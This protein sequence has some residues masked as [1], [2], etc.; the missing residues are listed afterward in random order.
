MPYQMKFASWPITEG[1]LLTVSFSGRIDEPQYG[2]MPQELA[3]ALSGTSPSHVLVV[4]L[5]NELA[6]SAFGPGA[7]VH[8]MVA[9]RQVNPGVRLALVLDRQFEDL[10]RLCGMDHIA[11]IYRTEL[12]AFGQFDGWKRVPETPRRRTS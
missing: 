1:S 9:A 6:D 4:M 3:A 11:E 2:N 7:L 8:V 5:D 10:F 12:E